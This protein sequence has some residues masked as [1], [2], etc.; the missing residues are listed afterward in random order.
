MAEV[1]GK[2]ASIINRLKRQKEA[3]RTL[4]SYVSYRLLE[5]FIWEKIYYILKKMAQSLLVNIDTRTKRI[6]SKYDALLTQ[7]KELR[8]TARQL[9]LDSIQLNMVREKIGE[10]KE[11]LSLFDIDSLEEALEFYKKLPREE[12]ER[13]E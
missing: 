4:E 13:T 1:K 3:R 9:E 6:A 10:M 5:K 7:K 12:L 11:D 8:D 2:N